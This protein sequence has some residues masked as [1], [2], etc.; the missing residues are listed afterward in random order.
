MPVVRF[1]R[2]VMP[3]VTILIMARLATGV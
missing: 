1:Y 3:I 2:G